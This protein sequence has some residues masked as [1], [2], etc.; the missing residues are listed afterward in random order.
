[1]RRQPEYVLVPPNRRC[2]SHPHKNTST[3]IANH[4]WGIWGL[5]AATTWVQWR[6]ILV[7][8]KQECHGTP[9]HNP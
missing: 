5:A 7:P 4:A 2:R 8:H 3:Y 6:V 9:L 1:M